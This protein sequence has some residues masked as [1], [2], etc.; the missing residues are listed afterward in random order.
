MECTIRAP[1]P[2]RVAASAAATA[3]FEEES[4]QQQP[5]EDN[6][7]NSSRSRPP[8]RTRRRQRTATTTAA[9]A[10]HQAINSLVVRNHCLLFIIL[11]GFN[12]VWLQ[13]AS[14]QRV[15]YHSECGESPVVKYKELAKSIG[16]YNPACNN[17]FH[18]LPINKGKFHYTKN[19]K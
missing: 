19:Q 5:D 11:V 3:A 10:A 9:A 13:T 8:S 6:N 17:I 7:T 15:L 18:I 1:R 12:L 14:A 16:K 4:N 2:D